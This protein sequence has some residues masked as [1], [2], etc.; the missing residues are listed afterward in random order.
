MTREEAIYQIKQ[1][2]I[3]ST[4]K[5]MS[6][7]TEALDMAIEAL[8]T[9]EINCV[10]CPHYYETKDETGVHGHCEQ[11]HGRLIDADA[12]IENFKKLNEWLDLDEEAEIVSL[13]NNAPTAQTD[14]PYGE[15]ID[16]GEYAVCSECGGSSGTQYD[17]VERIPRIT[18]FCPHCGVR[19]TKGGEE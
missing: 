1:L 14:R 16:K 3:L 12:L 9:A 11:P 8:Q 5:E 15:W 6:S 7:I 13:I 4:D 18:A 2:A 17:G 10:H 19:M